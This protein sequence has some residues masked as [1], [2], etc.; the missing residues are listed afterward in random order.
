[1][2]GEGNTPAAPATAQVAISYEAPC[3]RCHDTGYID[4]S[5]IGDLCDC[6]AA[7]LG[8]DVKFLRCHALAEQRCISAGAR[9]VPELR[10]AAATEGRADVGALRE[11][12]GR[13]AVPRIVARPMIKPGSIEEV[14]ENFTTEQRLRAFRIDVLGTPAPKGSGRAILIRGKARHVPSGSNTNRDALKSWD[15]A[16]RE[17]ALAAVGDVQAP[18]FVDTAI[19]ITIVFHMKRPGSHYRAD[20]TIKPKAPKHPKSKPDVSKLA[21]ATEDTLSGIVF[22]DDARVVDAH[23]RKVWAAPGREGATITITE[24][25]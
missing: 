6:V 25:T 8:D 20:G 13:S 2:N 3:P 24:A 17:A 15:V 18:P 23:V 7:C 16:V 12:D 11:A 19:A 10:H 4:G 14:F 5:I 22:D 1:M 21:R 9:T